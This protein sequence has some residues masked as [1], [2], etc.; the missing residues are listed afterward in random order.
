MID[1]EV[2]VTYIILVKNVFFSGD[3]MVRYTVAW[4]SWQ[5]KQICKLRLLLLTIRRISTLKYVCVVHKWYPHL[6][7]YAHMYVRSI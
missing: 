5:E 3:M 1:S 4:I 6:E 7:I 2:A